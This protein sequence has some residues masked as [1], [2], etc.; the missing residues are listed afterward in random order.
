MKFSAICLLILGCVGQGFAQQENED[1]K[2]DPES[3][4]TVERMSVTGSLIEREDYVA[5][6]PIVTLDAQTFDDFGA[7]SPDQLLDLLPQNVASFGARSNNPANAGIATI[8]LRGLGPNRTL[9]LIDGMRAMRSDGANLVD[10]SII[11]TELLR[12]VEIISGGGSATYGSDAVAGVVNFLLDHRYEGFSISGQYGITE[13]D[14]GEEADF[15]VVYG[16]RFS[17]GK[18]GFVAFASYA[19]R[20]EVSAQDRSRTSWP[21]DRFRD[22]SGAIVNRFIPG[23]LEE[24]AALLF[25]NPPSQEAV[26]EV[27][28]GFGIAPGLDICA[29]N[30]CSVGVNQ[31]GSL[32]SLSP[33]ENFRDPLPDVITDPFGGNFDDPG[34]LQLPLERWT[35]G[36]LA[37]TEVN[38]RV[39]LYSRFTFTQRETK[40]LIGSV[41][42]GG[43]SSIP[44]D[45]NNAFIPIPADLRTLLDSR[46]NPE[47]PFFIERVFS[48]LG[49]RG[50]IFEDDHFQILG[51]LRAR[52]SDSWSLSAHAS[53]GELN[54]DERQP[55]SLNI[56]AITQLLTGQADCGGF[57]LLGRNSITPTCADFIEFVPRT[58]TNFDQTVVEAVASG[59]VLSMPA[60]DL[61]LAIGAGYREN[62]RDFDGDEFT[63]AGNTVGFRAEDFDDGSIDVKEFFGEI[64]IPLLSDMPGAEL[65]EGSV[66]YR[67]SDW[68]TAGGVQSFKGELNYKPISD[69]RLRASFQRAIR[70]PNLNEVFL[71]TSDTNENLPE[72]PCSVNSTF[73]QGSVTGVD[74]G[75]VRGLCIEQGIPASVIDNFVGVTSVSG[76][77]QGNK[78]LSEETGDTYSAGVVWTPS[79]ALSISIDYYQIDVDDFINFSSVNPLLQRCFNAFGANPSL[80]NDSNFCQVFG[81]D[82]LT[83]AIVDIQRTFSNVSFVRREGIDLQL[84]HVS[85]LPRGAG[86]VSVNALVSYLGEASERAFVGEQLVDFAGSVGRR[87]GQTLPEWRMLNTFSWALSGDLRF[88]VRWRFIDGMKNRLAVENPQNTSAVGVDSVNYFDLTG[89]WRINKNTRVS[90]GLLNAA[91]KQ[92]PIFTSPVDF[93]TDPNTYDVLGRRF[94]ARLTYGF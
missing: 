63:L 4:Q 36:L 49:G 21:I 90:L 3:E 51:G 75:A 1:E 15:E 5:S 78:N 76:T 12:S 57:A 40:R 87:I 45:P 74:P 42:L 52:I 34:L 30:V 50:A 88:N 66:G 72:D 93:N 22:S 85:S 81:R 28:G 13:E 31:D 11:P 58:E 20:N 77:T 68:S 89:S 8:N 67:Y 47:G 27:F 62:S 38:D 43:G 10:L 59:P 48:E 6:S 7:T 25:G 79:E 24:G 46:P 2:A 19:D 14:D 83:G 73:R 55:G 53:Y 54:R 86:E 80:S 71:G 26:D 69:V 18:H 64:A 35:V 61:L 65:L 37:D 16:K 9:V 94:F 56:Q 92:P 70:A 33:L 60:G 82:P 44:V 41:S 32:F 91:D 17:G 29:G 84:D 39:E 23:R